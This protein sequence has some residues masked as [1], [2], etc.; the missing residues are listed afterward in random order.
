MAALV[1]VT[2]VT[3]P[4]LEEIC[5]AMRDADKREIFPLRPH[6][7][8]HTLALE[9]WVA[10]GHQGRGV[11]AWVD[12]RPAA[13]IGFCE[14]R[15]NV[16]DAVSFGTADYRYCGVHL[17][18]EGRRMAREI[19][20]DLGANRLQ[21]DSIVDNHEAHKFIQALGGKPEGPPMKHFGKGGEDYQRFVWLRAEGAAKLVGVAA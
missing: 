8:W 10:L 2:G 3:L 15:P 20:T 18:R 1:T 6:D 16:W 14:M 21:A 11:I 9:A 13:C 17:M 4:A 19:L 5:W 12:G 7:Q